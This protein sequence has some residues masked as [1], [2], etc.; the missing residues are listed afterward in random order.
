MK[1]TRAKKYSLCQREH[2]I[3]VL[4]VIV[5]LL[6]VVGAGLAYRRQTVQPQPV[7]TT[8]VPAQAAT[9]EAPSSVEGRYLFSGTV[10]LARAV[11]RA[12]A[13]N[14]EQPF[15]GLSS[16][17]PS[18]Y[19]G[20]LVDLECPVTS[21][22]VSY[23]EQVTNLVFNCRPEWLPAM[24]RY[25]TMVNLAN[26]HTGDMGAAGFLETQKQLDTAG[27]QA[28]GSVDPAVTEDACEVMA[29]PVRITGLA[30]KVTK[31]TLPVAFCAF[32]YF[33]R[34]PNPGELDII[35]KYAK[36][37]PVFGLMH[38]GAEYIPTAGA[39]Q[40][41]IAR[42]LIDNGSEF[43]IGN[44]PHW[45]QDSEVYKGKPIFYST[46]NFIFDQLDAETRRGLSIDVSFSVQYSDELAQWLKLGDSCNQRRDD[47]LAQAKQQ[48]L[49]K[50]QLKLT[51]LPVASTGGNKKITTKGDTS[52][53]SG[54]ED[55]LGWQAVSKALGQ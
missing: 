32:H 36:H 6:F 18:K 5:A 33:F 21:K 42:S 37:M 10:V 51:Y 4:V 29:L 19:D 39:Q 12:A 11:E 28:V 47:C 20:W 55:R 41:D 40:R 22:N 1:I 50:P 3:W 8:A 16:F 15:S 25:F 45:V 14:Y 43:V 34:G 38:A 52:V 54:V 13:G 17:E 27:I 44:S 35:S 30:D 48:N 23:Q 49:A 53:Q 31:G 24:S 26:N 7:A 2:H 46:G 9:P